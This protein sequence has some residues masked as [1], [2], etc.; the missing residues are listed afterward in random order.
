MR[1]YI[2]SEERLALFKPENKLDEA[3]FSLLGIGMIIYL[4]VQVTSIGA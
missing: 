4:V 2:T 3:L 1:D